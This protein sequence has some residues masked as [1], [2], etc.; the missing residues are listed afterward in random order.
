[1]FI[2]QNEFFRHFHVPSCLKVRFSLCFLFSI[3]FSEN[4]IFFCL[5]GKLVPKGTCWLRVSL[6]MSK[7]KQRRHKRLQIGN[8][9]QTFG[10]ICPFLASTIGIYIYR[11]NSKVELSDADIGLQVPLFVLFSHYRLDMAKRIQQRC[12]L[13]CFSYSKLTKGR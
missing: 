6:F 3:F 12:L 9:C 5:I 11:P 13:R 2:C 4:S 8:Y 1:M 7:S 10:K